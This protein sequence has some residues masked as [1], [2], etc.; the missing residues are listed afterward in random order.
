MREV[1]TGQETSN[2]REERAS[3]EV[4]QVKVT[5]GVNQRNERTLFIVIVIS[6]QGLVFNRVHQIIERVK[7][8]TND[9]IFAGLQTKS[10]SLF[11]LMIDDVIPVLGCCVDISRASA[12]LHSAWVH[13]YA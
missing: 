5:Y 8:L 12:M 10:Q 2:L 7:D 4:R 3:E 6:V 1:I 13:T 9:V 11:F